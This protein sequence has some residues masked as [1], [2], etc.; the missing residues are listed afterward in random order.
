M[1]WKDVAGKV[2]AAGAPVIG[3]A[4]FG[5]LGGM[6]GQ[7]LAGA[8]GAEPTPQAVA[9]KIADAPPAEVEAAEKKALAELEAMARVAEAELSARSAVAI[10][11]VE[12][13]NA[14]IRATAG[15]DGLLGK[16]RGVHAWELTAECPLWFALFAYCLVFDP[17][18]LNALVAAS[19]LVSVYIGARFGVLGVHV[20][21][22]SNERQAATRVLPRTTLFPD[23]VR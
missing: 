7:V 17:S 22:G 2:I 9:R 23:V 21:Q 6:A 16:W 10:A 4:L 15:G 14:T 11:G 8:L 3:G 12:Q 18:A 20:W 1:D 13:V 19:G 5:P